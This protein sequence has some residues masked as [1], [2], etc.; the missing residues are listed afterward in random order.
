MPCVPGRKI[1]PFL[2]FRIVDTILLSPA[3]ES[4]P[5]VLHPFDVGAIGL[6][7]KCI[8]VLWAVP[9]IMVCRTCR[10]DLV[11]VPMRAAVVGKPLLLPWSWRQL[12]LLRGTRA[13]LSGCSSAVAVIVALR[14]RIAST[15]PVC[16]NPCNFGVLVSVPCTPTGHWFVILPSQFREECLKGDPMAG[17]ASLAVCPEEAQQCSTPCFLKQPSCM[18]CTARLQIRLFQ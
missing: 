18:A 1:C 16:Q 2:R 12:L 9:R 3:D 13:R 4:D 10:P 17:S 14:P 5:R 6:I 7:H 15:S 8:F 11:L